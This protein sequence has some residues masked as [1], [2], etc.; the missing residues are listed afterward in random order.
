MRCFFFFAAAFGYAAATLYQ[1]RRHF[2][3]LYAAAMRCHADFDALLMKCRQFT[4][5]THSVDAT[6]P[7]LILRY[8]F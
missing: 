4:C 2:H 7:C 3:M 5:F 6:S 1:L 8:L